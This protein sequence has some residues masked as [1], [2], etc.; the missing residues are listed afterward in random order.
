M[1]KPGTHHWN[2]QQRVI[3]G[4]P[5]AEAIRDEVEAANATRVLVATTRSLTNG[6]LVAGVVDALG[7]RCAGKFD[8]ITAHTPRT[9]VIAGAAFARERGIDL[10]VAVGGGSVID[11]AK[12][13]L[14]CVWRDIRSTQAMDPLLAAPIENS[15]WDT[16]P[17]RLRMIAVPTTLSA[18]EFSPTAGVT[19]T[20]AHKKQRFNH[21][22]MVPKSVVL[23]PVATLNTPQELLLSS[24]M[25]AMDHAVERWLSIAPSAYADAVSQ[26]AMGMLAHAL[27][28]IRRDPANLEVRLEAQ[29]AAWLSTLG[30]A[31]RTPVGA[32]HGLGYILGAVKGVPHGVTSCITLPAV[33]AWNEAVNGE[34]QK[35]VAAKLG[36]PDTRASDAMRTFVASLGVPGRL[37]DVGIVRADLADLASRYDGSAP[38]SNNPRPVRGPQD[39][40]EILE[41]A[42]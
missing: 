31:A 22:M 20:I 37:R 2:A 35:V 27:P 8:A 36:A 40:L 13:M 4:R 19:D 23:D 9:S 24:G 28:A 39:L 30:E 18:A 15:A 7:P 38:I 12:A 32:S 26:Q 42:L 6:P 10:I 3:H 14:L 33:L 41:L 29:M 16:D 1:I 5:A 34:R 17:Q 11:C 21:P 25:R